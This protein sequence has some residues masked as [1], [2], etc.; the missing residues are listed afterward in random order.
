MNF[1]LMCLRR[2]CVFLT[3]FMWL[4]C[5]A[6]R[7]KEK[8]WIHTPRKIND[9]L[10]LFVVRVKKCAMCKKDMVVTPPKSWYLC[11]RDAIR[12]S[13]FKVNSPNDFRNQALRAGYV[14]QSHIMLYGDHICD[15]CDDIRMDNMAKA[16][17]KKEQSRGFGEYDGK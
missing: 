4:I 16:M 17:Q 9:D 1:L 15:D 8:K 3:S 5:Y 10:A 13:T 7:K 2:V 11:P 6:F 14:S 12:T